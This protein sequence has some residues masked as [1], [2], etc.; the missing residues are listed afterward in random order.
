MGMDEVLWFYECFLCMCLYFVT[1]EYI[2][3]FQL[4]N[5]LVYLSFHQG[6]SMSRESGDN[7]SDSLGPEVTIDNWS[8][9]MACERS[10]EW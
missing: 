7:S 6:I 9:M 3:D 8:P 2:E 1:L 5:I 10:T 4:N